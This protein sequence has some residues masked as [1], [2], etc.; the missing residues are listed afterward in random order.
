MSLALGEAI[1][2]KHTLKQ[3]RKRKNFRKQFLAA[4]VVGYATIF[5]DLM[6]QGSCDFT[7]V[8]GSM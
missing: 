3:W 8:K 6:D 5:S 4:R 1:E 7:Q 2:G